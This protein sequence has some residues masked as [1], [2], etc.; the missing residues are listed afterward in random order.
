VAP[1]AKFSDPPR[2]SDDQ[3][4]EDRAKSIAL[5]VA[6]RKAADPAKWADKMA[7]VGA[8]VREVFTLTDNLRAITGG[9]LLDDPARWWHILRYCCG[10]PV[11]EEDLWT[12]VGGPL[13]DKV[14]AAWADA[15]ADVFRQFVDPVR[16]PW[17]AQGRAPSAA[18]MERAIAATAMPL[19]QQRFATSGR[20]EAAKRQ[21][22]AVAV[23][24]EAA[25]FDL[26]PL[27]GRIDV[28]DDMARG[29][30]SRERRLAGDKC[31]VPVRLRDGRILAI[32]CKSS[33]GPK[34]GWKR[35]QREVA[36]KAETWARTFGR[37]LIT[38]AV[39]AGA[40]DLA[41]LR[42]A[43]ERNVSL[44]WEHNLDPLAT[45]VMAAK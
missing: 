29:T 43:Q 30:F 6:E 18:E 9:A 1:A 5:F 42:T 44:F 8:L 32:E 36:G 26:D 40:Y 38:A 37:Q 3:L 15:T 21:E 39:L 13:F 31:D 12:Y 10:P 33:N 7:E 14:P 17:V 34:N 19:A 45:F 28:L 16:F 35:V 4:A 27:R 41:V 20:G 24:L 25:G 22:A 2:W 11:S 23:V